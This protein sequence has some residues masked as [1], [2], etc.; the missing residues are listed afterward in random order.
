MNESRVLIEADMHDD[1]YG[2]AIALMKVVLMHSLS[3][4]NAGSMS[5]DEHANLVRIEELIRT[6]DNS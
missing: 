5:S 1:P 2:T 3:D 6:S 4:A